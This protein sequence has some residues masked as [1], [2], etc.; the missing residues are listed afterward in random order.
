MLGVQQKRMVLN[1]VQN[2]IIAL[3]VPMA[4]QTDNIELPLRNLAYASNMQPI[5]EMSG[6]DTNGTNN[7][8]YF[9][10]ETGQSLAMIGE[11]PYME[12]GEIEV[13]RPYHGRNGLTVTPVTLKV[14]AMRP[15]K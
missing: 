15:H 10:D 4:Q 12:L 9:T 2:N 6:L 5:F 1:S 11:A 7:T 3:Q 14:F 13:K 8:F